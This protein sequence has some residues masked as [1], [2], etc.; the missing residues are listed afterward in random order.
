MMSWK[1]LERYSL[2]RAEENMSSQTEMSWDNSISILT[3][4]QAG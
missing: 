1:E 4:L 3:R 2:R